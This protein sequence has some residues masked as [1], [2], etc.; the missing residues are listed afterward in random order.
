MSQRVCC[1]V[2]MVLWLAAPGA[3]GSA[4]LPLVFEEDFEKGADRWEPTDKSAWKVVKTD[5]GHVYNQFK[6]SSYKPPHRSPL[7]MSLVK[8]LTVTDFVLE[9]RVHSTGKDGAHRDMCLF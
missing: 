8:D 3:G 5:K 7:N 4:E 9:A 2:F 1:V 6:N